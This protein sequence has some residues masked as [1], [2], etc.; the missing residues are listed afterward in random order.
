MRIIHITQ[1]LGIGGLEKVL[2]SL[3]LEQIKLGHIVEV[4]VYDHDKRWVEKFQNAGITVH[5]SYQKKSGLDFNTCKY[6]ASKIRGADIVHTHD[7]NPVIYVIMLK[8]L[9]FL[10]FKKTP[11]FVHTTHGL[12]HLDRHPY[13]KFFEIMLGLMAKKIFAV[14]PGIEQFYRKLALCQ[15]KKIA[16]IGNGTSI[17]EK[18]IIT[19]IAQH[20][21]NLCTEFGF[22]PKKN[23]GIYV[24][25]V[26][27]LKAQHLIM[28]YYQKMDD[29][30][31]IVGPSGDDLYYKSC[32]QL[33][34]PNK[35]VM[36]GAREDIATLLQGCDYFI[37]NSTHE[38]LPIAVLEAGAQDL[39]CLVSNIP[40]HTMFN[41]ENDCVMIF[42]DLSELGKK[43]SI[44][45]EN[46]K[47]L[48]SNFRNLIEE[49]YSS[50]TMAKN[51]ILHY[52]GS[53]KC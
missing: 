17:N 11:T 10:Q 18:P 50:Q 39:P 46:K 44:L 14:S 26:L 12:G 51:Y 38:G 7:L 1:F 37:S 53:L 49:K 40:G 6:L 42:N 15:N 9:N 32:E 29:Q 45:M 13:Y 2:Y 52:Q 31:L 35:I 19:P 25:R 23:I 47:K 33:S 34:I 43:I 16:F 22:D 48:T 41:A 21:E 27:P 24:A 4:I 3:A 28:Q 8:V 5:D 36:S 20:R 30:L